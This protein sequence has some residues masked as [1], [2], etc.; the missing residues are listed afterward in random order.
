MTIS[1]ITFKAEPAKTTIEIPQPKQEQINAVNSNKSIIGDY[2][3]KLTH[4]KNIEEA[5]LVP[6]LTSGSLILIGGIIPSRALT[7]IFNLL[8][9]IPLVYGSVNTSR[10]AQSMTEQMKLNATQNKD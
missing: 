2:F 8:A 5:S 7:K 4:P 3:E 10:I 6:M 1:S 9:L